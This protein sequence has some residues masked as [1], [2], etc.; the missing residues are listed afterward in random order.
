MTGSTGTITYTLDAASLALGFTVD[1]ASGAVN[2]GTATART[3]SVTVTA[4]D[5]TAP[6]GAATA[7]VGVTTFSVTVS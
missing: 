5:D 1:P 6:T 7:G 4:T 2:V 3:V